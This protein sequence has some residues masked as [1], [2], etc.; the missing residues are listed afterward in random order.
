MN[1][2][3]QLIHAN[4]AAIKKKI[5]AAAKRSGRSGKDITLLGVTKNV[6]AADVRIALAAGIK[7]LGENKVQEAKDKFSQ[8]GPAV[9][10]HMLGH[11]QSNKIRSAVLIFNLVQSVDSNR[12]ADL[13]DRESRR[14]DR[15]MDVLIEVNIGKEESKFGVSPEETE[16]LVR[17]AANKPALRVRGLM[18]MAPYVPDPEMTRP[19]FRDL[20]GIFKGLRN[21]VIHD[22]QWNI[23][24]LGMTHDFEV[25]I[26]EGS[27]L[28]RIGTGI[29]HTP[30]LGSL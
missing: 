21:R 29:F 19:F 6:P 22:S 5:N 7:V 3:S 13:L 8:I 15:R 4:I 12:T 9:R 26:E 28:V 17:Y 10:W 1:N 20:A 16:A 11:L 18:A 30:G 14:L 25:A 27:N 2:R 24:S 23:L